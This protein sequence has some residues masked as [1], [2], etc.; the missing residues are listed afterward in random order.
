M[1]GALVKVACERRVSGV[2]TVVAATAELRSSAVLAGSGSTKNKNIV[3]N[4]NLIIIL[5][6]VLQYT[7]F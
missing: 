7:V 3:R 1:T 4:M 6:T 2:T 5:Y